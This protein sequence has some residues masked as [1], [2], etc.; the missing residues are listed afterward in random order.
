MWGGMLCR[1]RYIDDRLTE[2][3]GGIEA[4]VNLGAGL[5]TRAYRLPLLASMPTW[6]VD[7]AEVIEQKRAALRKA[8]DS[9]PPNVTLVPIDFDNEDVREALKTR[10]YSTERR[11]FFVLEGVTQY[12]T[13]KG[14][15]STFD[16]MATAT[17][18]SRLVFTYVEKDFLDG[19]YL[20]GWEKAYKKFVKGGIW[21]LGLDPEELAAF[22]AGYGWRLVE[23]RGYDELAEKYITQTGRTFVTTTV[24]RI[25]LA[26]KM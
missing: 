6:E 20:R 7:Q 17:R 18:G 22:L 19:R 12:L 26:E 16:F 1:K 23:D 14:L 8:F 15:L 13:E 5:D 25:A 9:L 3:A 10:G 11:T 2:A 4:V 24:E 21:L